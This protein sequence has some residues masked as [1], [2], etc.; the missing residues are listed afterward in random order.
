MV[1]QCVH[2]GESAGF[3]VFAAGGVSFLRVMFVSLQMQG[4]RVS[5]SGKEYVDSQHLLISFMALPWM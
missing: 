4:L 5:D 1:P 2:E 3:A